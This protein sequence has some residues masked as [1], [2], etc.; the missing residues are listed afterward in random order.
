M[1][2]FI[3]LFCKKKIIENL[4]NKMKFDCYHYKKL[5]KNNI[6]HRIQYP[7]CRINLH[8]RISVLN[9]NYLKQ[10][11]IIFFFVEKI[12]CFQICYLLF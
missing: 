11:F 6:H 5:K 3:L 1:Q 9:S 8:I 4:I 12:F 7:G 2:R 10:E